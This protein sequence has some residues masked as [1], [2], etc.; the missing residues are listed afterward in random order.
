MGRTC[1]G[2]KG[3]ETQM[4]ESREMRAVRS[5]SQGEVG[6]GEA[7]GIGKCRQN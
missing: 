2:Q 7:G 3:E 1:V 6:V 5:E 4:W